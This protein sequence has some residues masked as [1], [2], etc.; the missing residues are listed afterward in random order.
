ME[1]KILF[2]TG[3]FLVNTP[4]LAGNALYYSA[5][6]V[7]SNLRTETT[8]VTTQTSPASTTT[9]SGVSASQ[10][11]NLALRTGYKFKSRLSD[12]YFWAPEFNLESF[13]NSFI[14]GTHLRFGYE[15]APYEIYTS[16]GVSRIQ[17]FTDN[18]LN[19]VL[20]LEYR[21][22]NTTSLNF[23]LGAYDNI[24]EQTSSTTV[25][26]LNTIT[27]KTN[28]VRKINSFKITYTYYFEGSK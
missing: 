4:L 19:L 3:L 23:E 17:K 12:R 8:T 6:I 1:R 20:G 18:R 26:G 25:V 13:D 22:S 7:S 14:Y 27:V 24:R 16:L 9:S 10:S 28:T 15:F 5:G 11:A 21:L 2:F